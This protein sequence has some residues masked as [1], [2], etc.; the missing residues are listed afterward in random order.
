MRAKFLSS[1]LTVTTT[2]SLSLEL[3]SA[4]FWSTGMARTPCLMWTR[5]WERLT[6]TMSVLTT[7]SA[8]R[9]DACSLAPCSTRI[10]IT[11]MLITWTRRMV[12]CTLST[13]RDWR[14]SRTRSDSLTES[15]GTTTRTKCSMLTAMT[16]T[17]SSTITISR[18][19]TSVSYSNYA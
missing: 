5:F 11:E 14:S 17:L 2:T 4:C 18:L 16:W 19:E 6:T 12:V 9:M 7:E 15:H 10:T 13:T 1:S 3:D 8:T